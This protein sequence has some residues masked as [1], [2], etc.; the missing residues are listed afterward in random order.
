MLLLFVVLIGATVVLA[1]CRS[2][3]D[4][5][6]SNSYKAS[7]QRRFGGPKQQLKHVQQS[8]IAVDSTSDGSISPD[9]DTSLSLEDEGG[10]SRPTEDEQSAQD[11]EDPIPDS[12]PVQINLATESKASP[13]TK[14]EQSAQDIQDPIPDS[15][16]VQINLATESKASQPTKDEQSAKDIEDP[17][18]DPPPLQINLA[19]DEDPSQNPVPDLMDVGL[20]VPAPYTSS[21]D[22]IPDPPSLQNNGPTDGDPSHKN[23]PNLMD[24]G[25]EV[26]APDTSSKEPLV[27]DESNETEQHLS[28]EKRAESLPE[29][30][31]VP[32]EEAVKNEVLQGWEDEWVS[33]GTY[34]VEKWGKLEEPKID[35][36]YLWVNGSESDFQQTIRPWE[37]RSILNDAEGEWINSHGVN[38]YRDWDELRYSFR[39]I[40]KNAGHFMNTIKVLVNSI[41]KNGTPVR[42]Q[43]PTWLAFDDP[44]VSKLVQVISQE[45]MFEN[46]KKVCL[47]AFNS[48]TIENQIFNTKSE[49]DQFFAM[50]D[51]MLLTRE[52]AP[53]DIY[54]P[55]FGA[56]MSFK[57]NGYS[58]TSAPT[59]AD[60]HRF[61]EKPYLIYTSWLLNRRFG[62]RK[63]KG[64]SHFGHSLSRSIMREA[65]E[66][67]PRSEIQ[68]AC[69][70]FRGEPGF[71]LYSWYV[72]NHYIIERHRELLLWSYIMLRS[73]VDR[74][75]ILS[76]EERQTIAAELKR[77]HKNAEKAAFR[78]KIFYHVPSMLEEAGLRAPQV[79][80]NSLWT[81]LDGPHAIRNVDCAEF[82]LDNCLALG[83]LT[84]NSN[85]SHTNPTFSAAVI[86]DRLA[87]QNPHCGDCLLKGL[88]Q[89]TPSGLSPLLPHADT[90]AA[91]RE[92]V[93]KGAMRYKFIEVDPGDTL[94]VMVTD[95]DQIDST[96][97]RHYV[98]E[99]KQLPGQMCLN[100]DVATTDEQE[101]QDIQHAMR[102]TLAGLFP[103][104]GFAER[105]K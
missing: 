72:T 61:G 68:S 67:F 28:L 85:T 91:D 86:F 93:V 35:F 23:V 78:R 105:R 8:P 73:D 94:F 22:P 54:S 21:K 30:V 3:I 47:P 92:L 76:W 59:E 14:D 29:F 96:L 87:R 50:S 82:A 83:F 16:P 79:N 46:D 6:H 40:E 100:D 27:E 11:V 45:E 33:S 80:T 62:V 63:R 17:I 20:E 32:F 9:V 12:S 60:A 84:D 49:V 36:V 75:G 42:K 18:P 70:R 2:S 53:A 39:S 64:Q 1:S 41:Y 10:A 13:P 58:T 99:H 77:G 34:D 26:P 48:L 98:K 31:W 66:A 88:L 7:L 5:R 71:Q 24:P 95:A 37:E 104:K 25:I 74:D 90:Q 55:L 102:E 56:V 89:Q 4:Y 44:L 52:H 69:K 57:T 97:Y 38:R 19:T 65:I 51:D 43:A 81:S 103:D 101:L 15:S